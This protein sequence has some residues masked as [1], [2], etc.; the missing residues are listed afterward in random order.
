MYSRL[1]N[2]SMRM[3]YYIHVII[4][5]I[6]VHVFSEIRNTSF[7]I[8]DT[9][10][11]HVQMNRVPPDVCETIQRVRVRHVRARV[12]I[13]L[14]MGLQLRCSSPCVAV[15]ISETL[16]IDRRVSFHSRIFKKRCNMWSALAHCR[17]CRY[18]V[19]SY[20]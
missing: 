7:R 18:I 17:S 10:P 11:P 5:I 19:Q 16:S 1:D 13:G 8:Y 15:S 9:P 14:T 4:I 20:Y 12:R 6:I 3:N 2:I